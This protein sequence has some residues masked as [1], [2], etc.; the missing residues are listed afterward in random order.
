MVVSNSAMSLAQGPAL[1][2]CGIIASTTA[3][4]AKQV[5]LDFRI[6]IPFGARLAND[7]AR[8]RDARLLRASKLC[9]G[10]NKIVGDARPLEPGPTWTFFKIGREG[11]RKAIPGYDACTR[12]NLSN[13][14][15]SRMEC[16]AA[17]AILRSKQPTR[18]VRRLAI[19]KQRSP[20]LSRS[21]PFSATDSCAWRKS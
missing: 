11:R 10:S 21:S 8:G 2:N 16:R 15:H 12:K 18:C 1:A 9:D 14:N 20:C 13:R 19:F 7:V 5:D 17:P 4:T 3:I 6:E